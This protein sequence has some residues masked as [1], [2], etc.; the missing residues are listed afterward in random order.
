MINQSTLQYKSLWSYTEGD[1][2]ADALMQLGFGD[3]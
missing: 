3:R 1:I 2:S